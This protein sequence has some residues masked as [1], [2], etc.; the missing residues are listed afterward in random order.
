MARDRAE[1]LASVPAFRDDAAKVARLQ[2]ERA[3]QQVNALYKNYPF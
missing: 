1:R 2:Y 3:T